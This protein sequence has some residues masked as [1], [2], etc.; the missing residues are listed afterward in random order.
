LIAHETGPFIPVRIPPGLRAAF[1]D[2]RDETSVQMDIRPVVLV[3]HH[4]H[5]RVVNRENV[6]RRQIVAES[7]LDGFAPS[8]GD[9][10]AEMLEIVI[11]AVSPQAGWVGQSGCN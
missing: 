2:P 1:A 3:A 5:D 6:S 10:S 7:D 4:P 9:N 8:G 11:L